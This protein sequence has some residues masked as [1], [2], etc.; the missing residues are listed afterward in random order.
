MAQ[1][2]RSTRAETSKQ[3][4]GKKKT[5]GKRAERAASVAVLE[6]NEEHLAGFRRGLEQAMTDVTDQ[7]ERAID[8]VDHDAARGIGTVE[9]SVNDACVAIDAQV[10]DLAEIGRSFGPRLDTQVRSLTEELEASVRGSLVTLE[11]ALRTHESKARGSLVTFEEALSE[12]EREAAAH[13]ASQASVVEE[14]ADQQVARITRTARSAATAADAS[15]EAA[16]V[17]ARQLEAKLAVLDAD[18]EA[19]AQKVFAA[20]DA[21]EQVAVERQLAAAHAIH[22][23]VTEPP[24][25]GTSATR[26]PAT[27]DPEIEVPVTAPPVSAP[28]VEATPADDDGL[29]SEPVAAVA[30]A[31]VPSRAADRFSTSIPVRVITPLGMLDASARALA[32]TASDGR[33]RV[34]VVHRSLPG[35]ALGSFL[36]LTVHDVEGSWEY[37]DIPARADLLAPRAAVLDLQETLE[38]LDALRQYDDANSDVHLCIDDDVTI[39]NTLLLARHDRDPELSF[40]RKRIERI[41]L[42]AAG[43]D[44]LPL[45]TQLGRLE[46]PPRLISLLRSRRATEVELITVDGQACV[47]AVVGAPSASV[48]ATIVARLPDTT[49]HASALTRQRRE[50]AGD[51]IAHLVSAL[52]ADTG[53]DELARILADGVGYTRRLA[54]AHPNLPTSLIDELLD[55]GTDAMRA[56][57][58]TNPS[59]GVDALARA[60]ADESPLVRTAVAGNAQVDADQLAALASDVD[61]SVRAKTAAN[62]TATAPLLCGLAGDDDPLVRAAVA[63]HPATPDDA[64]VTLAGDTDAAVCAAVAQNPNCPIDA[65]QDL[66]SVVPEAVMAS[67]H[68]P[69]ALLTA[70]SRIQSPLL[71]TTV[72]ANSATPNKLLD[73]LSRDDDAGVLRAVVE[74]PSSLATSR[75][76]ARRRLDALAEADALPL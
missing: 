63:A 51:E 35:S 16:V 73:A 36:R 31:T 24:A 33:V 41:D 12:L 62:A 71:R 18:I 72:A 52:S 64:L 14:H 38:A 47:S 58:A 56:A 49:D 22:Q 43:R 57:A 20:L 42:P 70:G 4:S 17:L 10:E 40:D 2:E 46:V 66:A 30:T 21:I 15:T 45:E 76:R 25:T 53:A 26:I 44:G 50:H 39:G 75:R 68:A 60:V 55:D 54:A 27:H 61:A 74:N 19:R 11:A 5:S 13:A 3:K 6:R 7:L 28:L 23:P 69:V 37:H 48:S 59:I 9:R 65:L 1:G 34:E 29:V 67:R 32:R 8:A